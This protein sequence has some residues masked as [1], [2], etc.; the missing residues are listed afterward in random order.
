MKHE[1]AKTQQQLRFVHSSVSGQQDSGGLRT[2]YFQ[3]VRTS[4]YTNGSPRATLDQEGSTQGEAPLGRCIGESGG[5]D[6][7]EPR[8]R[9][10]GGTAE[11]YHSRVAS[12]PI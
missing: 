5:R 2:P 10:G 6:V 4:F 1:K 8:G 11:H 7:V 12:N 9:G 3:G